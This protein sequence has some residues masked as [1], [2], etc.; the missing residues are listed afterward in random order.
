MLG[1]GAE[2][3]LKD[4]SDGSEIRGGTWWLSLDGVLEQGLKVRGEHRDSLFEIYVLN[5]DNEVYRVEILTAP[6]ATGEICFWVYS[7]IELCAE[8]AKEPENPVR[9][10]CG[11]REYGTDNVTDRDVIS[12]RVQMVF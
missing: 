10:F 1:A 8:G 11:Y 2:R 9:V 12:K 5:T 4:V 7:S 6:K 3:M